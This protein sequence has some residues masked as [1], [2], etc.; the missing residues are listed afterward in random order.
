MN[1]LAL[2]TSSNVLHLA[3]KTDKEFIA[4][5]RTIGR[6]FSE[7]LVVRMKELCNEVSLKLA[8]LSLIVCTNGPGSFTGLRVGMAAA[9]GVSLAAGIPL[10]SL[11]T[12][13]IYAYPL[14]Y[15]EMPVLCTMD[16]KKNRYYGALFQQGNRLTT[17]MDASIAS[18][19]DKIVEFEAIL[20][21]GPDSTVVGDALRDEVTKRGKTT[22]IYL[23]QLH[24]RSYGESMI[25]LGMDLL[26]QKGPDDIGSGPT[27]IRKSDAEVSLEERIAKSTPKEV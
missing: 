14:R 8:D 20:I 22:K 3:L 9:K 19:C 2:E 13:E 12:M 16:A 21:T 17:D 11:S 1:V 6:H 18:L 25:Q 4:S 5:T 15:A 26:Q 27:Y 24:Y 10:V 23:D 7:E